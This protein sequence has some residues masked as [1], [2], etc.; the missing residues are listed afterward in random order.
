MFYDDSTDR[1]RMSI[2]I[3][4]ALPANASSRAI[5]TSP[6]GQ[7]RPGISLSDQISL[8]S[9]GPYLICGKAVLPP[10]NWKYGWLVD[11]TQR[12]KYP[13][14]MRRIGWR[15]GAAHGG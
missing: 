1:R 15:Q 3:S 8:K 12:H 14:S 9:N 13:D 4:W 11:R 2:G 6:I 5:A 7:L 10:C